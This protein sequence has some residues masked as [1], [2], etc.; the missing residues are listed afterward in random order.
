MEVGVS[1]CTLQIILIM[2]LEWAWWLVLCKPDTFLLKSNI[3]ILNRRNDTIASPQKK[4]DTFGSGQEQQKVTFLDDVAAWC[5]FNYS[6]FALLMGL[7]CTITSLPRGVLPN[8]PNY[9]SFLTITSIHD[10]SSIT[11]SYRYRSL[12]VVRSKFD[13]VMDLWKKTKTF[14]RKLNQMHHWWW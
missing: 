14:F 2:N 8:A 7:A 13:V 6:M 3:T 1:A 12:A 4:F 5:V 11:I 10:V 9:N